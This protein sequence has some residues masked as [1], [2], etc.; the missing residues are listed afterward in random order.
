MMNRIHEKSEGGELNIGITLKETILKVCRDMV[1]VKGL[2]ALSMC[3]V[4]DKSQIA[5]GIFYL[6]C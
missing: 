2:A 5:L 1:A 3:S 4:V 6:Y